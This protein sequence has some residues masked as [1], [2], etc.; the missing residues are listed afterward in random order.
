MATETSRTDPKP[1]FLGAHC[2]VPRPV[3]RR[4]PASHLDA[5]DVGGGMRL[6][7]NELGTDEIN[8]KRWCEIINLNLNLNYVLPPTLPAF[9]ARTVAN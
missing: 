5:R 3:S 2:S 4:R 8:W 7:A 1:E 6:P 9:L